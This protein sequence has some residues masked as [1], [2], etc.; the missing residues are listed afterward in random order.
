VG[1]QLALY[2]DKQFRPVWYVRSEIEVNLER[3][4]TF[5]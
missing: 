4:E 2:A 1:D 5:E 3:V